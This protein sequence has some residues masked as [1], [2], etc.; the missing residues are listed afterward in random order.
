[1][2]LAAARAALRTGLTLN[3]H[4]GRSEEAPAAICKLLADAYGPG[5]LARVVI[6]HIDRTLFQAPSRLDL[7]RTGVTLEVS[8]QHGTAV[9]AYHRC[10][11]VRLVWDGDLSLFV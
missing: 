3:V 4:P 6:S 5:V 8:F 11:A 10:S 2:L 1:V 9:Y 7:A